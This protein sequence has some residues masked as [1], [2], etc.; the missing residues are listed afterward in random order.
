MT[1]RSA[2]P[3]GGEV[4]GDEVGRGRLGE[5]RPGSG[6]GGGRGGSGHSG[7]PVFGKG[8]KERMGRASW[9]FS[10]RGGSTG[11]ACLSSFDA[12]TGRGGELMDWMDFERWG[13]H[14]PVGTSRCRRGSNKA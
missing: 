5:Q 4:V 9:G 8:G 3:G 11:S 1:V 13:D 6:G 2:A 7:E 10:P 14:H 12:G